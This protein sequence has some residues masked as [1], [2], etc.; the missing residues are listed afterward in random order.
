MH[1]QADI[2]C[3]HER[4]DVQACA[5]AV[6]NPVTVNVNQGL[7]SLNKILNRDLGDAKTVSRILE[8]LCIAIGAEQLHTAVSSAVGLH[9]LKNFL[10]VMEHHGS[11]VQRQGGIRHNAGIMPAFTGGIVHQEHMVGK[12]LA[13]AKLAF[14]LRLCLRFS[15]TNNFDIQHYFLLSLFSTA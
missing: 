12:N 7:N 4:A 2:V 14:V 6:G 9:A 13:E 11:G 10:C 15:S 8:T 3:K 1:A 5:V